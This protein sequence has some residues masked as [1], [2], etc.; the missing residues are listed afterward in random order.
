MTDQEPGLINVINKIFPNSQRIACLFH[1]K[2]DILRNLKTY[3][4]YKDSIK[5]ESQNLLKDLGK[6]PF[7]YNGDMNIFDEECK[8]LKKNI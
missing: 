4:L 6:I 3:G 8:R 5:E 1:F 2:Q 7:Y